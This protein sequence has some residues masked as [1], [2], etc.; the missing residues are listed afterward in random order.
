M[1][2]TLSYTGA[3]VE[4]IRVGEIYY[5]GQLWDGDGDGEELLESGAIA[6][7]NEEAEDWEVVDFEIVKENEN[8]LNTEVRVL[9]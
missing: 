3:V 7:Y 9:R 4:E 2:R 5:F 8:I 6:V 1:L